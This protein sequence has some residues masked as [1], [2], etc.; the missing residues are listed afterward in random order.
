MSRRAVVLALLA[1]IGT[2]GGYWV[3]KG[4]RLWP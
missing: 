1:F 4:Y 2:M 3:S